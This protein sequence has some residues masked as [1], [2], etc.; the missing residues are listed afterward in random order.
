MEA[1]S[2]GI[3][4]QPLSL[5]THGLCSYSELNQTFIHFTVPS[6]NNYCSISEL[7]KGPE[8]FQPCV[9]QIPCAKSDA[10]YMAHKYCLHELTLRSHSN[11]LKY[12]I[13]WLL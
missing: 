11:C 3:K 8:G 9:P 4:L 10:K 6:I 5:I 1:L 13:D 2:G 12:K 7:K